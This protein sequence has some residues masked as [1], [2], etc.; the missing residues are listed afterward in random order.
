MGALLRTAALPV[1]AF[2]LLAWSLVCLVPGDR[3][4]GSVGTTAVA[5]MGATVALVTLLAIPVITLAVRNRRWVS[6][7]AAAVAAVLPWV[8]LASYASGNQPTQAAR[9]AGELRVMVVNAQEGRASA[10]DIVATV[11]GNS[12]EVLVVTELTGPLA[13]DLTTAG[14]DRQVSA[15]WVRLPGEHGVSSD[16]QA[17]MGV[18]ARAKV[19][20]SSDVAGTVW[21]SV[22]LPLL[23]TQTDQTASQNEDAVLVTVVA[24]HVATPL[25]IGGSRWVRDLEALRSGAASTDGPVVLLGNLNA[26]PWHAE[27]R[28]Y[29]RTG[30]RDAADMMGRGPRPTWPTWSPVPF[31]PLD[32]VMVGGGMGVNSIETVVIDGSDHRGLL[33]SLRLPAP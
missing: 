30:L 16:P 6:L 12:I 4:P 21:P 11:T 25:P 27:L 20:G 28:A 32:H 24:G 7:A 26:T 33:A 22:A 14:L 23:A 29:T 17:G 13:H 31:L 19:G 15:R 10:E 5:A 18:W 3:A 9:T 1:S 2:L 8:F